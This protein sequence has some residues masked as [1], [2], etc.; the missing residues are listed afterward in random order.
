VLVVPG[1]DGRPVILGLLL[2]T[3]P[4]EV[5]LDLSRVGVFRVQGKDNHPP[6]EEEVVFGG[7]KRVQRV[8][9][10]GGLGGVTGGFRA[11]GLKVYH[12]NVGVRYSACR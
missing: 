12:Y 5:V 4:Q 10:H 8:Y 9:L 7:V 1:A 3:R 2:Q 6:Q 11:M